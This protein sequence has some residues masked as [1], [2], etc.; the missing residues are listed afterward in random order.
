MSAKEASRISATEKAEHGLPQ[1]TK[2]GEE[3]P[4]KIATEFPKSETGEETWQFAR[5]AQ[6]GGGQR[7]MRGCT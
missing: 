1:V 3:V 4:C 7:P 2:Q 6:G 5:Q